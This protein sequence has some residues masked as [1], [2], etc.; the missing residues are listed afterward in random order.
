LGGLDLSFPQRSFHPR[1]HDIWLE[2]HVR[3]GRRIAIRL[4]TAKQMIDRL[5][6]HAVAL[7]LGLII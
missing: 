3:R 7:H 6:A 5:V 4:L 1:S 2:T